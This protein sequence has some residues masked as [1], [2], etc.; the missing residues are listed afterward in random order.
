[1]FKESKRRSFAKMISWRICATLTTMTLVYIFVRKAYIAVSVGVFEVITKMILYF[2]HERVWDKVKL[3]RKETDP[4]VMW[5]T[6]LPSS[7]KST[8]A[9]RAYNY[10]RKK[11]C[12]VESLDGDVVREMFPNTGFS[13]EER[14]AHIRRIGFLASMLE[15]NGVIVIA[16]FISPYKESRDF[17]KELSNNFIEVYVSTSLAE[18][19]KRDVKGLYRKARNGEIKNFTGLDDPYEI[20]ESPH[21]VIDTEKLSVKDSFSEIKQTINQYL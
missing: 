18:C 10:L 4:F 12:R 5:F 15:K 6:G 16:S 8:L 14:K 17:V 11:G 2:F 13:Q 3:G 21:I 7:G 19:E 9:D 1:M 20:P